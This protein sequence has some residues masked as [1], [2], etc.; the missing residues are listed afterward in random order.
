ML[1]MMDE[2]QSARLQRL[3]EVGRGLVTELDLDT[4]LDRILAVARELTGAR[5]AALGVL[6]EG[7]QELERFVTSGIDAATH[8]TI[9]DLPRGRGVLGTL[10]TDPRPLRLEDVGAHPESYGFPV[11]HPPMKAF[12]GVPIIIRGEAWGNLYLTE[13]E[14]GEPFDAGDEEATV[15][16]ADWAAIAIG[17]ARLYQR[18]RSRRNE[19]EHAVRGFETTSEIARALGGETEIDRVLEL[20]VKRGRAL[21]SAR[22]MIIALAEGDEVVLRLA[23]GEID[24]SVVGLRAPLAGS[25]AGHVMR[26]RRPE[27]LSELREHAE[28]VWKDAV[29]AEAGLFVPLVYRGRA[30]GVLAAFDRVEDGPEFHAED[31]RLMQSFAAAG[32]S[33]VATAQ[34]VA[35]EGVRRALAASEQ[36]RRRWARELHDETLQDLAAVRMLLSTARRAGDAEQLGAA[37]DE[38]VEHLARGVDSLRALITDLRPAALDE[39]GLGAALAGLARPALRARR[40]H[41]PRARARVDAV[42]HR[43][44]GADERRQARGRVAGGSRGRLGGG[45]DP[46]PRPRRRRGVRGRLAHRGLRPRGDAGAC[47]ARRRGAARHVLAR[48]R[49]GDPRHAPRPDGR[50]GCRRGWVVRAA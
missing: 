22:S 23:A 36:E 7:R 34:N 14:G 2:P 33:A 17:N 24:R 39:L 19:L 44:G 37:V 5:Y 50:E 3:I 41:P 20:I 21:V 32:A 6:D 47:R 30:L 43:P 35:A 13:K 49:D 8:A 15:V 18:E 29:A 31:E 4:L 10:I 40:E 42:P 26:A 45:A 11:G 25:M 16:L 48:R 27:R 12:L 1:R 38:A 46:H 28:F 9:G